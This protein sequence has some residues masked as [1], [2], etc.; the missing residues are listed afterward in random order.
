MRGRDEAEGAS[1][2]TIGDRHHLLAGL[3]IDVD[4]AGLGVGEASRPEAGGR[5]R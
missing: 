2:R 4:R 5:I 1:G 3:A